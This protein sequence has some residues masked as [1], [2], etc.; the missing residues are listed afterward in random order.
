MKKVLIISFAAILAILAGCE[1]EYAPPTLSTPNS[2]TIETGAAV[3]LTFSYTADGGFKSATVTGTNGTASI[4]TNGTK[5]ETSGSIVVTFTAG[6]AAGAGA[7]NLTIMDDQDQTATS[8]AV[9]TVFEEG[10][11]EVTAPANTDVQVI[12]SVDLTFAF[13]SE[14]GYSSSSVNTNNGTAALK[15]E[16]SAGATSGNVVV[17]FTASRNVG[18]GSVELTITDENSKSGLAT[19]V[20]NVTAFPSIDV[21]EDIASD[22]TWDSDTI[23]ILDGRITVLDG[24]TLT[25]EAGTVIKAREGSGS[26][27]KALLIARGGKLLAQGTS[28]APIIF[29]SIADQILPGEIASPNMDPTTNGLWGGLLVLGKAPISADAPSV[30]IEGIPP[31]DP[32]GLYGG[33]DPTDNSGIIQYVSIR[34]GGAN[35]GEGNE[36]NGLTLGGVGSGTIIDHIEIVSN[37]D[38]GIEWF[39]GKV[40]VSHV[41]V[42]NTGDDAIDADQSYGGTVDNIAI[43]NPGDECFE[44]DG[45]EGTM[46][47]KYTLMN[48]SAY[49]GIAEGLVDNDA[50]T[51]VDMMNVYFFGLDETLETL[52]DFDEVPS[53]YTCVFSNF[54]VTLPTGTAITDFFKDGSD[55]FTTA[56]AAGANTVGADVTEF[57]GWTWTAVSG[58][59][60]EF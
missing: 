36:I 10:A 16:P 26:N 29:T 13:T 51:W 27:A 25:I 30:Q 21:D 22:V 54:E 48:V 1:K 5:G 46:A 44:L 9:I 23:Y 18:A 19:A 15:T 37:Q 41:V 49:A 58:S 28:A 40:N 53:D 12:K 3:D 6:S 47:D 11:P 50:N 7:V 59:L 32:N 20:L 4:K 24:I 35:I 17:T 42:W 45:P 31:S 2:Q 34:H 52:Q 39:G 43:V 57:A 33:D 38:D 56:V 8:T 55:A 60:N 14:G